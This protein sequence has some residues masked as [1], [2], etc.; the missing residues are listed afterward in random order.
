M[1]LLA[2]V[3]TKGLERNYYVSEELLASLYERSKEFLF[4]SMSVSAF[5]CFI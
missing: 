2:G 3:S 1:G 5:A 4:M